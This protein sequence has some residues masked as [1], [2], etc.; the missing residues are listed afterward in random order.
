MNLRDLTCVPSLPVTR[1][2]LGGSGFSLPPTRGGRL[3]YLQLVSTP[4]RLFLSRNKPHRSFN[5]PW[6]LF[7]RYVTK[8]WKKVQ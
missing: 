4:L 7:M 3:F 8:S 6:F 5:N 2:S 1:D